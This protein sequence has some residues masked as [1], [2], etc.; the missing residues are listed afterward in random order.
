MKHIKSRIAAILCAA[1]TTICAAQAISASA[2]SAPTMSP[3]GQSLAWN[4][5]T[6]YPQWFVERNTNSQYN[7]GL[8]PGKYW[9]GGDAFSCT[10]NP[11]AAANSAPV[12]LMTGVHYSYNYPAQGAT[13]LTG[14]KGFARTLAAMYFQTNAFMRGAGAD[15]N[16]APQFGDQIMLRKTVN[17]S[18]QDYRA[19]FIYGMDNH[20]NY[21]YAYCDQ[22]DHNKIHWDGVG[23]MHNGVWLDGSNNDICSIQYVDR[24][25]LMGDVNGDG[26]VTDA[27]FNF[28][29]DFLYGE[30]IDYS[31]TVNAAFVN[32]VADTNGDG[33]INW[34]DY[35]TIGQNEN[36]LLKNNAR[37]GFLVSF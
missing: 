15:I 1:T 11:Y 30:F 6:Y 31:G 35:T 22:N 8:K 20:Y 29:R 7:Y 14:S 9:N 19:I 17:G 23:A 12:G 24:P 34:T 21:L 32:A 26:K 36:G 37:N 13:T 33:Q 3:V 2:F 27:D 28:V 18:N 16:F 5:T 25:I 4:F 10:S